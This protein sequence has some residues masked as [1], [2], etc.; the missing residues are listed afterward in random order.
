MGG[1]I[2]RTYFPNLDF[3][4]ERASYRAF[5][6]AQ[7][8]A[9]LPVERALTEAGAA[10]LVPGWTKTLR[11]PR[12]IDD[13]AA[14]GISDIPEVAAP[15]Y[16]DEAATLG[17]LYVLEGSRMGAAVLERMVPADFP[18]YIFLSARLP[19]TGRRSLRHLNENSTRPL[20]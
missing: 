13:L 4:T 9:F 5:L 16:G 15:T 8:A 6:I 7:A 14:L 10:E 17:G 20:S 18:T 1:P 3:I 19:G 2:G 12:L 11:S